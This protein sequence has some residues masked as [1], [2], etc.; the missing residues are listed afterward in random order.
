MK[1]MVMMRCERFGG[2]RRDIAVDAIVGD[3]GGK[4]VAILL[5]NIFTTGFRMWYGVPLMTGDA[6][7]IDLPGISERIATGARQSGVRAGCSSTM[8]LLNKEPSDLL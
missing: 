5:K 1:H 6:I 8:A 4:P 3:D 2:A 7:G